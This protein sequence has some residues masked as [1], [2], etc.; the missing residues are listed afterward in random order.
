MKPKSIKFAA[1]TIHEANMRLLFQLYEVYDDREAAN[2]A[3]LIMEHITGWKRIDRVYNKQVKMSDVMMSELEKYTHELLTHK[4]VQY[5]LGEAWFMGMKFYVDEHVLIPR[6]ETEELVDGIVRDIKSSGTKKTILDIGTGSGCI[7]V[8]LKK[9][10]PNSNVYAVDVSKE[11]LAVAAKNAAQNDTVVQL[12]HAD[13]LNEE[14]WNEL[15]SAEIIV[16]N[17]P[18]IPSS[19]KGMMKDNVTKFEPHLALFVPDPDPLLFYK[20][21]VRFAGKKLLPGGKIYAEMHENFAEAVKKIFSALGDVEIKM[22]MQ[23]KERFIE[24]PSY[25]P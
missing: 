25:Q 10:L 21:I 20:V 18:Y 12:I 14:K 8:S 2:V 15:P 6:P 19:E 13:I 22:D 3:D 7:A 4:P 23:G 24:L 17:P 5:I 11:A 1:M 16:S 9:Y